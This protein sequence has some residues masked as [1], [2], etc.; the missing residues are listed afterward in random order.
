MQNAVISIRSGNITPF[1][2]DYKTGFSHYGKFPQY[3]FRIKDGD[4]T[5]LYEYPVS[6]HELRD[7]LGFISTITF[8]IPGS[9][10]ILID[11]YT[12]IIRP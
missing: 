10:G 9:N 3:D 2:L 8:D 5:K 12:L 7:D 6:A 4:H 11:D 1:V